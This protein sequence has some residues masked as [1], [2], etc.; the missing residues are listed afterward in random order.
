MSYQ[1]IVM[2]TSAGGMKAL[3]ELLPLLPA[4]FPLPVMIV[5]H[6]QAGTDDF[7]SNYLDSKCRIKVKE[8]SSGEPI[9]PCTA[10]LAPSGYHLLV[11][12]DHTLS[13]SVDEKICYAR[14]SIDVLFES[15][16]DVYRNNLIGIILSGANN[17][18]S[19]GIGKI[20][21]YGGLAIAQD[22]DEA[23]SMFMPDYA[24]RHNK[25]DHIL[26]LSEISRQLIKIL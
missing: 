24:I 17:D 8:A 19:A 20:N 4:D 12:M 14:P 7:L 9:H 6:M 18:G 16:A 15:A 26:K 13:L 2:G 22:P 25:I 23:E 5:Q 21:D 3:G 11:E 10:Y 1:A